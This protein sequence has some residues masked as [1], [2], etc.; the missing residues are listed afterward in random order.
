MAASPFL[1]LST[2]LDLYN[3][4][5][6]NINSPLPYYIIPTQELL[7][8]LY[9]QINKYCF[10]FKHILAHTAMTYS[11]PEIIVMV[12]TLQAL[13]FYYNTSL[14]QKESLLYK[15]LKEGL[16]IR[17]TIERYSLKDNILV[18]NLLMHEEYKR[19]W[20]AIKNL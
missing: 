2:S 12:V 10:L 6:N 7:G 11:L 20:Q 14:I 15:N 4:S 3:N 5:I 17:D 16:N 8:F 1:K 19:K 18:R 13:R 9:A